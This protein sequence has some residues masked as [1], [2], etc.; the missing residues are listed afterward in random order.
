MISL[1]DI[2]TI[3]NGHRVFNFENTVQY[4][5]YK[6]KQMFGDSFH[7]HA[8][9]Y[10]VIYRMLIW[11]IQDETNAKR[12]N[13]ELHKGLLLS[14]PVGC[15]KTT[16]MQLFTQMVPRPMMFKIKPARLIALDFSKQGYD[17]IHNYSRLTRISLSLCL[18]DIGAEP[19]M[20]HFGTPISVIG[21]ILLSRY[22]MFVSNGVY[23][24]A[25]TNLNANELAIRYGERVRSR[26][27]S[28]F[29]LI[30]FESESKDKR[31]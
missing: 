24:H 29:N 1:S 7:I 21:E 5:Q 20:K 17:I 25:T 16:L 15:G 18:D 27:R 3:Q 19:E 14:G 30:S 4:L 26:M 9:D 23:T 22:D 8:V 2:I 31:V 10:E 6:G 11:A 28:M 13:I 12:Y